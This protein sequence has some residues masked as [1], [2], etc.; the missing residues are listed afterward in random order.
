MNTIETDRL[1]FREIVE[2]DDYSILELDSDSVV[3]Q[4]L[5]NR[6]IE[7]IIQAR[8]LI[9]FIR[10]QYLDNGIGRLAIIEKETNTFVGWG[11]FKLITDSVNNHKNYLDLG[12]R[13]IRKYWG[14]GYATESSNAAIK[15]AFNKLGVDVIYAIT[16]VNNIQSKKVLQ[17]CGFICREVFE[18][19][20]LPHYWFEMQNDNKSY[21]DM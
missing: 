15:F 6:P 10:Q 19:Q 20:T 16:D 21:H 18:Y 7:D 13:F 9:Q 8:K 11:G 5:G 2:S 1:Y 3:H 4:Y 17:K 12:Y 14:K